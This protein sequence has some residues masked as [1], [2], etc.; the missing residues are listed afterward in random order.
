MALPI[1]FTTLS[2]LERRHI[3]ETMQNV[4]REIREGNFMPEGTDAAD[5]I[6]EDAVEVLRILGADDVEE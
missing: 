6:E 5:Q 2:E 1:D 4:L 3:V